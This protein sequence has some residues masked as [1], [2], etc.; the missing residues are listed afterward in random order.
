MDPLDGSSVSGPAAVSNVVRV[1]HRKEGSLVVANS[2]QG[3]K[4]EVELSDLQ[5]VRVWL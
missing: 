3:D 4:V 5:N 1:Q 2:G